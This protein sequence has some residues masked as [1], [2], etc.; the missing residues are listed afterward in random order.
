MTRF[1]LLTFALFTSAC[2]AEGDTNF[3]DSTDEYRASMEDIDA[4]GDRSA[5]LNERIVRSTVHRYS[6][7]ME[8]Y[9]CQ[10]Q[11][12]VYGAWSTKTDGF[13]GQILTLQGE[14]VARVTGTVRKGTN[15]LGLIA[16]KTTSGLSVSGEYYGEYV[17]KG[18]VDGSNIEADF[19]ALENGSDYEFFADSKL[20]GRF[21]HVRGVLAVCQ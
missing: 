14:S 4:N 19:H 8:K 5:N 2:A 21:N 3:D 11:S 20:K 1:A 15:G 6:S 16:G 13:R 12:V 9:G 17:F 7:L 18:L 10:V